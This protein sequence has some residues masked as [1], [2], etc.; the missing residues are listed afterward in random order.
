MR[1]NRSLP[2]WLVILTLAPKS[3]ILLAIGFP[4]KY[5]SITTMDFDTFVVGPYIIMFHFP[6]LKT[7]LNN[8]FLKGASLFLH[9][10]MDMEGQKSLHKCL[11]T[12]PKHESGWAVRSTY[13]HQPNKQHT[14]KEKNSKMSF[15]YFRP[16]ST[17]S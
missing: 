3:R 17:A 16:L 15:H 4:A 9:L 8:L 14:L 1:R 11:K 13:Q 6:F 2:F 5:T 12:K 7:P 10:Q